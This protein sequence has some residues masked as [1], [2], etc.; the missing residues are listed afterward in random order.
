[1]NTVDIVNVV[2]YTLN[3][4][5]LVAIGIFSI[6]LRGLLSSN[7]SEINEQRKKLTGRDREALR[8]KLIA[9]GFSTVTISEVLDLLHTVRQI[10]LGSYRD[11]DPYIPDDPY[12]DVE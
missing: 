1:M 12:D 6:V 8:R 3:G 4:V 2:S 7:S 5:F 11:E 9:S 10:E